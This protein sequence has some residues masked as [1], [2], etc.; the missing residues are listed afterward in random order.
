[1]REVFLKKLR[2]AQSQA[3]IDALVRLKN[4]HHLIYSAE[5]FDCIF[6]REDKMLG[7]QGLL[8]VYSPSEPDALRDNLTRPG[9]REHLIQKIINRN[10]Q[11][12]LQYLLQQ[13]PALIHLGI[14]F[15]ARG[16]EYKEVGAVITF[17]VR[18]C[19]QHSIIETLLTF[20]PDLTLGNARGETV[21]H[22]LAKNDFLPVYSEETI[23]SLIQY[24]TLESIDAHDNGGETPLTVA[25]QEKN[26]MFIDLV[27]ERFTEA[28]CPQACS[29][30]QTAWRFGGK[31]PWRKPTDL[32]ASLAGKHYNE[33][34]SVG[35]VRVF[36]NSTILGEYFSLLLKKDNDFIIN[37]VLMSHKGEHAMNVLIARQANIVNVIVVDSGGGQWTDAATQTVL[38]DAA[39]AQG[40][41]CNIAR[42][43]EMIQ[44][45]DTGCHLIAAYLTGRFKKL[46]AQAIS[47]HV[48]KGDFD[49]SQAPLSFGLLKVCQS[50]KAIYKSASV[51]NADEQLKFFDM[52]E[53]NTGKKFNEKYIG[54]DNPPQN[55]TLARKNLNQLRHAQKA[56]MYNLREIFVVLLGLDVL[57]P[58]KGREIVDTIIHK[59]AALDWEVLYALP[60]WSAFDLG[61]ASTTAAPSVTLRFTGAADDSRPNSPQQSK[62]KPVR[63]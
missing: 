3:D 62:V 43:K 20:K 57:A 10:W 18:N 25:K 46:T 51:L 41:I 16:Q 42:F 38:N 2:T 55:H 35:D 6:E 54:I 15:C 24:A 19:A 63:G 50:F 1:M 27:R 31:T 9:S 49:L 22:F 32:L 40:L 60:A 37:G 29:L 48:A 33:R 44:H 4:E 5:M 17:A 36:I 23:R 52:L 59:D 28:Q 47:E 26:Q 34:G 12:G 7:L 11:E 30:E 8:R 61:S 53:T 45:T 39:Q 14:Y 13:N 56:L 21:F 58:E